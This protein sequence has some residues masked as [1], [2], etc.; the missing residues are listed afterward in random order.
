MVA[1]FGHV[2]ASTRQRVA[3]L[4]QKTNQ[5]NMTTRRYSEQDIE[6][7]AAADDWRVYWARVVDRFG[8]NGIV[9]VM[10]VEQQDS[11]WHIDTFLMSCRVIGR[12]VETAMLGVLVEQARQRGIERLV[13]QFIPTAKNAPAQKIYTENGFRCISEGDN[14]S[15]WEL[16]LTTENLVPP[17]WIECHLEQPEVK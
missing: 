15:H 4:T 9:G 12:T 17:E 6:R 7:L 8:D 10:I 5:L 16:N 2:D 11:V 13:G 3:Q 14:G 1:H